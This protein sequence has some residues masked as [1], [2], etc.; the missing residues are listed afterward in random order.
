MSVN[1]TTILAF[2]GSQINIDNS[3][4]NIKNKLSD[5][6]NY[7][8]LNNKIIY[9]TSYEQPMDRLISVI[10]TIVND[11]VIDCSIN[12]TIENPIYSFS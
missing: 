6:M 8:D 4:L 9:I 11:S 1:F 5:G 3:I 12:M 7:D 10:S 2:S